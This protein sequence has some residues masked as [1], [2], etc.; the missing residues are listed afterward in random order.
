M[1]T[2]WLPKSWHRAMT[3]LGIMLL[4]QSS[5][6]QVLLNE[7][8]STASGT[9]PP[10]G[11][12]NVANGVATD[13]WTFNN[14]GNRV[15]GAGTTSFGGTFAMWDSDFSSTSSAIGEDGTLTTPAFDASV[16]GGY[17]LEFDHQVRYLAGQLCEVDVWNGTTWTNVASYNTAD[18]GYNTSGNPAIHASIN[19]SAA[20][21]ASGVAKVRF[22][23]VGTDD[24][25]WAIDNVVITR[26]TCTTPNASVTN[27]SANNLCLGKSTTL[28]LGTTTTN[29]GYQWQSSPDN[30]TYTNI[31]GATGP[32]LTVTPT[33]PAYY[34]SVIT[35]SG[36]GIVSQNSTPVQVTLAHPAPVAT[37]ATRC[38][39]G[40]V[41]LAATGSNTL[42]WY[43]VPMGGAPV[44]TGTSFTPSISSSTTYYV[45]SE[46]VGTGTATIGTGSVVA[47]NNYVS[48]FYS[49]WS[50]THN[51][52]LV[53]ASELQ[54]QGLSA[55]NI[56]SLAI[57]ITVISSG[58]QQFSVKLGH[59]TATDLSAWLSPAFTTVFPAANV[60][61]VV[62]VN[63]LPFTTP[64]N[65]DGSSNI[66]IEVCHGNP[67]S[68]ATMNSSV[69]ADATTYIS[70][71]HAHASA[72]TA[73][74]V[75]CAN[76][77]GNL[78]TYLG[79]PKMTFAGQ[80]ACSGPRTQVVATVTPAPAF[81]VS[82]NHTVCNGEIKQMSV[83]STL[84]NYDNY[85]WSPA[86]DLYT[87]AA[88]T[89]PYVANANASTVYFKSTTAGVATYTAN[90]LNT[91][92]QCA[93]VGTITMTVLPSLANTTVNGT[94][95]FSCLSGASVMTLTPA[96]GYGAGSIQ[97][98]SSTDN[99]LFTDISGAA[100]ATYTSPVLTSSRYYRVTVKN[101]AGTVCFNTVSDTGV[102]YNPAVT[103][104][105][106]AERCGD[107]TLTLSATGVN[108]TL[109]WYTAAT[110]GT[111]AGTG[112]SFTTPVLN[113]TTTY[114]VSNYAGTRAVTTTIGN[115]TTLTSASSY[116][117]AFMNR[118][119][120]YWHQMVFTA[121]ELQ[122]A[123]LA[124]GNILALKFDI[125]SLGDAAN[126]TDYSI[127]LGTSA[128]ATLTGFT[129][130][131]LTTVYGPATYNQTIGTN[132]ITFT[133][134]YPWDGTSNLLVDIRH[135]GVDNLNNAITYYTATTGNT[136]VYAF[137]SN[138]TPSLYTSSPAATATANRLNTTFVYE[139][140]CQSA[141]TA[142]VATVN[143]Q[144]T[145]GASATNV[146]CFNGNDGTV[147]ATASSGTTPYGYSW[148]TTPVQTTA[149]ATGLTA[150]TY[151]VT[152]LDAKNC[153]ATASATVNNAPANT[154]PAIMGQPVNRT[155]CQGTGT[156]FS[157]TATGLNLTYRWW[158][159]IGANPFVQVNNG[160]VY[161]GA[162]T[163]T[164]TITNAP[165]SMNGY[166]YYCV[167]TGTC[168]P[169]LQS[170][171]VTLTV[172]PT[173]ATSVSVSPSATTVCAGTSVTF[174]ATG[175]NG[176]T[177]PVYRW[178]I[179]GGATV[180]TGN[181]FTTSTLANG[182]IVTCEMTSNA[183]CPVPAVA[184][185][186]GIT[187][188]VNAVV[189]PTI[190]VTANPGTT[191]C[192]GVGV[193]F[194]AT[195]TGGGT[196]PV[197]QWRRN[198]IPEGPNSATYVVNNLN[199]GDVITCRL[200][201]NYPCLTINNVFS[202]ALTMQ[203]ATVTTPTAVISSN[204]TTIC[205]GASVT[206]T[207]VVTNEG[208]V[209]T[210]TWMKNGVAIPGAANANTY[211]TT[212]LINS[213]LITVVLNSNKACV[214]TNNVV[215][216]GIQMIVDPIL[217]PSVSIGATPGT[218]VCA[219]T[220][221]TFNATPVN[222]GNTPQY[223][224]KLNGV[225]M[226]G[227]TAY[228]YSMTNLNDGDIVSCDM[229]SNYHCPAIPTVTSN[230]LTFT[231]QSTAPPVVSIN[232]S[233]DNRFI[234]GQD[235]TFTS[236]MVNGGTAPAYQ[237]QKNS[238]DI[239][240]AISADYKTNVLADGDK[241]TL[242]LM[243]NNSCANPNTA[244]SNSI[245][246]QDVTGVQVVS[247]RMKDVRLYPN[248]NK[249]EFI[250]EC[251]ANGAITA[252]TAHYEVLNNLGQVIRQGDI[253]VKGGSFKHNISMNEVSDGTYF[254]RITVGEEQLMKKFAIHR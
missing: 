105:T 174:T 252:N 158:V 36:S 127:M 163:A 107:G 91:S 13:V 101:G 10:A 74:S 120:Q 80:T 187:M 205:S 54:A 46:I 34:R 144:P 168:A 247:E 20:T 117:T 237:W 216:N 173:A 85:T 142:V 12:T 113:N 140:A 236:V 253:E 124:A 243:S 200:T 209:P 3:L 2:N 192:A 73:G 188:T 217:V 202:P 221:V 103:G 47:P 32:S 181:P 203:V 83:T 90:A 171:T 110:G 238:V 160:G 92:S 59:T 21:G 112:S 28:S 39:T 57:E 93:A 242:N 211:T 100:T 60:T 194:T 189:T 141:R 125:T 76:T 175:V 215:S 151:T 210:Y 4:A 250:V 81:A 167:A 37:P 179:N 145:V 155:I 26:T 8:F 33:V 204:D 218:S 31:S 251:D 51:Q 249:G 193:T 17:T 87:D 152:L 58:T 206:F 164:L 207:A 233:P 248:P 55:G 40:I 38:G 212:S 153:S 102:V 147:T 128:T 148:N 96:T 157:L 98:Q 61:P 240:G 84:A 232:V 25:W 230:D 71:R 69:L 62:G 199:D 27:A 177:A 53:L 182:D 23:Y 5:Q 208:T 195:A 108:P 156:T 29:A 64:F 95:T 244:T 106:P 180:F 214:S 109:N 72:A 198:N 43:T 186:T 14:P 172:N 225:S 42:N 132:T 154:I 197:Y 19:I 18:V 178:K 67:S 234:Q 99:V 224:W 130:T 121:A 143:P 35:C 184:V 185:S 165:T 161:S 82:A 131:G 159:K 44:G 126:V 146:T 241:I 191:F 111:L 1:F 138:T 123:G 6:A 9:T 50:N 45:G 7:N 104:T 11:W 134:P 89:V 196:A 88:A 15:I 139:G 30:V 63:T 66:V 162:T 116:P 183:V 229:N 16:P 48:P 77:T 201:S 166:Q 115:A 254:V 119:E 52:Y 65:W 97:W 235:V 79:K 78:T 220:L 169:V 228:T 239:P 56:T 170:N 190:T 150:G 136:T 222:G 245:T 129:T 223:Q 118:H 49:L 122:A 227:A 41:N 68:S 137:T 94:P 149:T 86:T 246:M 114:Y 133:T 70:T 135:K 231:I 226:S 213:D 22:H 75:V 219:G 24:W 176:G